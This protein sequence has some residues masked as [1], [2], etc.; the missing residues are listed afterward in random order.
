MTDQLGTTREVRHSFAHRFA[1]PGLASLGEVIHRRVIY[2]AILRC[3]GEQRMYAILRELESVAT[4]PER[5]L[6]DRQISRLG[7]TLDYVAGHVR[8]YDGMSGT[9]STPIER[10]REFPFLTKLDLQ[11]SRE[12]LE[13]DPAPKR[14]HAKTTG[15]STGEPVTVLK[16]ADAI[17]AERAATWLAYGW[18]GI[19]IADRGARFWGSPDRLGRRRLR[20]TLADFAMNRLRLSAFG[21]T[22]ESLADYWRRCRSFQPRYLYGYVSMLE[23]FARYVEAE[24]LDGTSLGVRCVVTTSEA[25]TE[26]QRYLLADVFGAP[27]QNE[28]G[29]GEV[30]PIAYS[31][32]KDSMHLMSDN[33]FI[34][35]LDDENREVDAGQE[36]AVVVTDLNNRA[37]PL[38]RYRLEDRAIRGGSCD[39]GLGFPVLGSIRGRE[40]DFV[41]TPD[42]RAFHGEYFMYLFEDLREAGHEIG[43]FK[44]IQTK[45]TSLDI[46]VEA[47]EE[48]SVAIT[49]AVRD[50]VDIPLGL[51]SNVRI[52]SN[53]GLE[54]SGKL[55]VIE[56]RVTGESP[57]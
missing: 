15:G 51:E 50:A 11:T 25:L 9:D 33:V 1:S 22:D 7:D 43:G 4:E 49:S 6:R 12:E 42:G 52:V 2:P 28:Y 13:A 44:I 54:G 19:R 18:Y 32:T 46:R 23:R 21:I 30:G 39:C 53:I 17:A 20:L 14:T 40:Y 35:L 57:R 26:P 5:L 47:P 41:T 27:V 16:D 34:E 48:A 31:C 10:L 45:P 56:N 55:R 24:G 36:G 29:C 8:R 37:M 3:R 38:V